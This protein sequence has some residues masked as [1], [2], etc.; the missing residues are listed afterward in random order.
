MKKFVW[1][2]ALI[3]S[4]SLLL[5]Q[6]AWINELHYD[7]T[8][9]DINEFVEVIIENSSSYSLSDFAIVLYNGNGGTVYGSYLL[10]TFTEGTTYGTFTIYSKW[11]TGWFMFK[12][13]KYFNYRSIL[14]I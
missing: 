6:N 3:F 13:S 11:S 7:D 9:V 10:D 1:L 5:A 8:G 4:F 2:V 14:I 12:L